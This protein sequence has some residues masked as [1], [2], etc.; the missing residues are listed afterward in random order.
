MTQLHYDWTDERVEFIK[1]N[2]TGGLSASQISDA[3]DTD[4]QGIRPSRNAVIG[5]L[6]RLGE[7]RDGEHVL[8]K[9]KPRRTRLH[10]KKREGLGFSEE[11]TTKGR[12]R[13]RLFFEKRK[14]VEPLLP[15]QPR[16]VHQLP[17]MLP[18]LGISLVDLAPNACRW[19]QGDS[20]FVFCGQ[21]QSCGSPY[22]NAHTVISRAPATQRDFDR[23]A[24]RCMG[25]MT[26]E[27]RIM[28]T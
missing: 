19:P 13:Q 4:E 10:H 21:P 6:N 28:P 22:C 9:R 15:P 2:W 27:S 12:Q 5:K 16:P 1:A 14:L 7:T 3:L 23:I 24:K 8:G 20:P 25:S 17:A 26:G 18:F 11:T